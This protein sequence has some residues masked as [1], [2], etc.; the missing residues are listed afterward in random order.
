MMEYLDCECTYF[1]SMTDD[2]PHHGGLQLRQAGTPAHEGF[3][4]V[5]IRADTIIAV[6]SSYIDTLTQ[7]EGEGLFWGVRC[8]IHTRFRETIGSYRENPYMRYGGNCVLSLMRGRAGWK[9]CAPIWKRRR[10]VPCCMR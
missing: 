5:L 1:P 4:P 6:F 3:V 7:T 10:A 8:L 2:D 9:R